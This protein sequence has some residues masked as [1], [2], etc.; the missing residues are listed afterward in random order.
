MRYRWR[1]QRT[2]WNLLDDPDFRGSQIDPRRMY[3]LTFGGTATSGNYTV[4]WTDPLTHVSGT[5]TVVRA[6]QTNA[7][8]ATDMAAAFE[9]ESDLDAL[10]AAAAATTTVVV[11]RTWLGRELVLSNPR[12]PT[13]GWLRIEGDGYRNG[14]EPNTF[15]SQFS[16][17]RS[18]GFGNNGRVGI[19]LIGIDG[20]GNPTAIGTMAASVQLID[21]ADRGTKA[22]PDAP[23]LVGGTAVVTGV[24]MA[25]P[26]YAEL[27]GSEGAAVR[28]S[29]IANPGSAIGVEVWIKEA[30]I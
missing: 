10:L 11:T 20:N 1:K 12:A 3:V 17:E 29:A 9:G 14:I 13:G 28:V 6:A 24:T 7:Q 26:Q 21:T 30:T 27:A 16:T 22:D 5:L 15:T 25:S 8:L 19:Q 2:K 23:A 4:D 18:L